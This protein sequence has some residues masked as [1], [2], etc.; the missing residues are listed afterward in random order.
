MHRLTRRALTVDLDAPLRSP[1][2]PSGTWR[3]A[4][5]RGDGERGE[6]RPAVAPELVDRPLLA[7]LVVALE[8]GAVAGREVRE[9]AVQV[10]D[11]GLVEEREPVARRLRLVGVDL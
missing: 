2:R 11:A 10:R 1:R 7:G 6:E 3:G 8:V 4:G 9:P 5:R